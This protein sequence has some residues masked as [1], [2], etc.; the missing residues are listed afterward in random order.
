MFPARSVL[1][2]SPLTTRTAAA[3]PSLLFTSQTLR[4]PAMRILHAAHVSQ[5]ASPVRE[6]RP[7]L[8]CG[9]PGGGGRTGEEGC[10]LFSVYSLYIGQV[11]PSQEDCM[12]EDC[13]EED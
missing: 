3:S 5:L 11:Q 7:L 4:R 10:V 13:M 6:H 12:E 2:S 8:G 1:L 9:F